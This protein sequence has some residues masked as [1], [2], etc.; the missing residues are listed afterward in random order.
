M[1]A[2]G[3]W[4]CGRQR[5]KAPRGV[6]QGQHV[7]ARVA[8]ACW[9]TCECVCKASAC[10]RSAAMG[11]NYEGRRMHLGGCA[12]LGAC[13]SVF[14]C[15]AKARH[16]RHSPPKLPPVLRQGVKGLNQLR[17]PVHPHIEAWLPAKE[18]NLVTGATR[19]GS[20]RAESAPND[21]TMTPRQ[22]S[23][24]RRQEAAPVPTDPTQPPPPAL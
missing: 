17:L 1:Q 16:L 22:C 6:S 20:A 18:V 7:G 13:M 9:R 3:G 19:A 2:A 21:T 24:A 10:V 23:L 12:G 5:G 11:R 14:G 8:H 4:G 15:R